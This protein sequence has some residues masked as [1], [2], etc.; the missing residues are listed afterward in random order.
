MPVAIPVGGAEA[1]DDRA[2]GRPEPRRH[3]LRRQSA[4]AV[5]ASGSALRRAERCGAADRARRREH[6]ALPHVQ[7]VG[8]ADAVP[9]REVALI[10]PVLPR[11]LIQRFAAAHDVHG[12][13]RDTRRRLFYRSQARAAHCEHQQHRQA[14]LHHRRA[15]VAAA[16]AARGHV[17][18]PST[19]GTKL[20]G[21]NS[22][23]LNSLPTRVT[24]TSVCRPRAP[25]GMIS[26]PPSSSCSQSSG[27]TCSGAAATRMPWNGA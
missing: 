15:D 10:E 4:A 17:E 21:I 13:A 26:T 8:I 11:D 16:R 7:H 23:R 14:E 20:T 19:N 2:V 5:A 25:I 22:S 6:E 12:R 18:V 3:R 27:G 1:H 24:R 9:A